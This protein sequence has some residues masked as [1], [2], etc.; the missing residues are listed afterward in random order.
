MVNFTLA[1]D[2]VLHKTEDALAM[3]QVDRAD[4]R[5][6]IPFDQQSLS[7]SGVLSKRRVSKIHWL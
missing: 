3:K 7:Q 2:P 1:R 5:S 4:P 6:G